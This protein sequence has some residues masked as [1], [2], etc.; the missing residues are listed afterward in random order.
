MLTRSLLFISEPTYLTQS[1]LPFHLHSYLRIPSFSFISPF[2]SYPTINHL[3]QVLTLLLY[4]SSSYFILSLT[5]LPLYPSSAF[6]LIFPSSSF[7]S[8]HI[9]HLLS[10]LSSRQSFYPLSSILLSFVCSSLYLQ[11]YAP[12]TASKWPIQAP[13]RPPMRLRSSPTSTMAT[14]WSSLLPL[15][16]TNYTLTSS[17]VAHPIIWANWWLQQMLLI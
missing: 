7:L 9:P 13:E 16:S 3:D 10:D 5:Y 8:S 4:F 1:L 12:N 15:R 14:L 11:N 2:P 6:S 17:G